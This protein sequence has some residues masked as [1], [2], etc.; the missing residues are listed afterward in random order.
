MK[1]ILNWNAIPEAFRVHCWLELN[2]ADH[3]SQNVR[4]EM[5]YADTGSWMS[6]LLPDDQFGPAHVIYFEDRIEVWR[7]RTS[8]SPC[9]EVVA[10]IDWNSPDLLDAVFDAATKEVSSDLSENCS[11]GRAEI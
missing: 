9:L 3:C 5:D 11:V 2:S 4:F 6:H 7:Y 10:K 1:K 8:D